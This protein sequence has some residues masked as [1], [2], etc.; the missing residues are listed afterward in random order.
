VFFLTFP[1]NT[2]RPINH[3][4]LNINNLPFITSY[5]PFVTNRHS[6]WCFGVSL[7]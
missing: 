1:I 4:A 6:A 7:Y 3:L 5:L 2:L